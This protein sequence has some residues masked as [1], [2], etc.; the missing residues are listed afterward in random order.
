MPRKGGLF[1]FFN[2]MNTEIL[3]TI[4]FVL[5]VLTAAIAA[6]YLKEYFD[7]AKNILRE[8][9][10]PAPKNYLKKAILSIL[11]TIIMALITIIT[12]QN[13]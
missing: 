9:S 1:L 2:T 11:A 12:K 6:H 3:R 5:S 10:A 8:S 7:S 13:T 4:T